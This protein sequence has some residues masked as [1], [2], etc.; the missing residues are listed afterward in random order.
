METNVWRN[1]FFSVAGKSGK[2]MT[3]TNE[4]QKKGQDGHNFF[5]HLFNLPGHGGEWN[6]LL[7]CSFYHF[8]AWVVFKRFFDGFLAYN[9]R[10]SWS[11]SL[12]SSIRKEESLGTL[13][14]SNFNVPHYEKSLCSCSAAL[15]SQISWSLCVTK[16]IF[17]FS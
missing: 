1:T 17:Q 11:R 16:R 8:P 9:L 2:K 14:P 4:S 13:R 3:R 5:D 6:I 7:L 12:G 10:S 15:K